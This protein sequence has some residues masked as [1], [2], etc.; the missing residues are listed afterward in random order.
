MVTGIEDALR[1][2]AKLKNQMELEVGTFRQPFLSRKESFFSVFDQK[3]RNLKMHKE[4]YLI[5][6]HTR[7]FVGKA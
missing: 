3:R 5:D 6:A 7:I 1:L 4:M 2:D